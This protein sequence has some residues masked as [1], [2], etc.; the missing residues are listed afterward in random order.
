MRAAPLKSSE[1]GA[2]L[3][4]ISGDS[5]RGRPLRA[6]HDNWESPR[7]WQVKESTYRIVLILRGTPSG[8]ID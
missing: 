5:E 6:W 3:L 7:K 8:D 1:S 2:I 4:L